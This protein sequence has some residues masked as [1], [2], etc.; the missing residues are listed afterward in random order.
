MIQQASAGTVL[1]CKECGCDKS[2]D[3]EK[4]IFC[5]PVTENGSTDY[6]FCNCSKAANFRLAQKT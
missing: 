3:E 2:K 4:R 5:L 1:C 6:G